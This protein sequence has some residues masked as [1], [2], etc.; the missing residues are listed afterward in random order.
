MHALYRAGNWPAL[1]A[2]TRGADSSARSDAFQLLVEH[3]PRATAQEA[4]VELLT[5]RT[6]LDDARAAWVIDELS[7]GAAP[8]VEIISPELRERYLCEFLDEDG[9]LAESAADLLA[10]IGTAGTVATLETLASRD[11][12]DR[13]RALAARIRARLGQGNLGLV[14]P[15]AAGGLALDE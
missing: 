4:A 7:E 9:T 2:E 8:L 6:G 15:D 14:D 10:R 13:A 3:G 12:D 11:H 5:R 1:M